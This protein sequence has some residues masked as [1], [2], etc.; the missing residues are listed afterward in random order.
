MS[1]LK[2]HHDD[3]IKTVTEVVKRCDTRTVQEVRA[4]SGSCAESYPC[5]GHGGV[6]IKFTNGE[7]FEHAC[8]SPGIGGVMYYYDVT[9]NHFTQYVDDE[10][11]GKIDELKKMHK[12]EATRQT[13]PLG[14][15]ENDTLCVIF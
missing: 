12:K 8:S 7:S 15:T 1:I 14:H 9:K 10:C 2:S 11:K 5:R 3:I 13:G 4:I 6:F